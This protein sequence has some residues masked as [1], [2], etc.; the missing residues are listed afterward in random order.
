MCAADFRPRRWLQGLVG[1][2]AVTAEC[3]LVPLPGCTLGQAHSAWMGGH[4]HSRLRAPT[5]CRPGTS[6]SYPLCP[7]F[8][9]GRG[10]SPGDSRVGPVRRSNGRNSCPSRGV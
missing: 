5:L 4:T 2:M 7:I 8:L 1:M 9:V 3:P 10:D 6:K